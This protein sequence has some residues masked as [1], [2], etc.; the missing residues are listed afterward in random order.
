MLPTPR[1][2][3]RPPVLFSP[4]ARTCRARG[5]GA[6]GEAVRDQRGSRLRQW[7]RVLHKSHRRQWGPE[8]DTAVL[9]ELTEPEAATCI[10]GTK[11]VQTG[12]VRPHGTSDSRGSECTQA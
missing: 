7:S 8:T 10:S 12:A 5:D 9:R 4:P 1:P 3:H 6:H 2:G 11:R